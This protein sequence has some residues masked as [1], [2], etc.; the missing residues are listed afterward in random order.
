[1]GGNAINQNTEHY[2]HKLV[3]EFGAELEP[4]AKQTHNPAVSELEKK[5]SIKK[6]ILLVAY[7]HAKN[8]LHKNYIPL[9]NRNAAES[10]HKNTDTN[11][12]IIDVSENEEKL[13]ARYNPFNVIKN[14]LVG[15]E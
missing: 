5:A 7:N 1:M 11:P 2:I 10:N 4:I 6:F 12:A 9:K 3:E 8:I 14:Y 15:N 13:Y